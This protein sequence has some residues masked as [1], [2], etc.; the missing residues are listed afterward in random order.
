MYLSRI[1]LSGYIICRRIFLCCRFCLMLILHVSGVSSIFCFESIESQHHKKK[2]MSV[3]NKGDG[4]GCG[5]LSLEKTSVRLVLQP[6][7][8]STMRSFLTSLLFLSTMHSENVG[9]LFQPLSALSSACRSCQCLEHNDETSPC[10]VLI[11]LQVSRFF[12]ALC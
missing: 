10:F 5:V 11:N 4:V 6:L 8:F 12:K 9:T 3:N 1:Q 7:F 2:Q